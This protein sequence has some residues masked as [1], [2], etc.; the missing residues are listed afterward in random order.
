M[1]QRGIRA[2]VARLA[3]CTRRLFGS[4]VAALPAG[5]VPA[6][7]IEQSVTPNFL[8]CLETGTRQVALRRHLVQ[9]LRMSPEQYRARW[10]LPPEYPM[11]AAA[12]AIRRKSV[13]N[14]PLTRKH[15]LGTAV[16]EIFQELFRPASE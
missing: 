11:V 6:V 7:P 14:L 10:G 8:I 1:T 3:G 15:G 13:Q 12:Y 2:C 4:R 16:V 9:T 5:R